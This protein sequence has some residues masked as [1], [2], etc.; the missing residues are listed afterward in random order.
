MQDSGTLHNLPNYTNFNILLTCWFHFSLISDTL[1]TPLLCQSE[2]NNDTNLSSDY[3]KYKIWVIVV[4]ENEK[5]SKGEME[6]NYSLIKSGLIYSSRI[7]KNGI[8]TKASIQQTKL[9]SEYKDGTT[10]LEY[11]S[12]SFFLFF[13]SFFFFVFFVFLLLLF[14]L[15]KTGA[16]IP[17]NWAWVKTKNWEIVGIPRSGLFALQIQ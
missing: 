6:V 2:T 13:S 14:K 4:S 16:K 11:S 15:S 3:Y 12:L 10:K 5:L 17:Y 1:I 8:I 9:V 7:S